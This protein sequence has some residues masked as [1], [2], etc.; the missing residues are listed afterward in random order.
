MNM[1]NITG[2]AKSHPLTTGAVVIGGG[3]TFILLSGWFTG[4][5]DSGGNVTVN[6]AGLSDAEVAASAQLESQRLAAQTQNYSTN[7][8]LKIAE[9]QA[10]LLGKQSELEYLFNIEEL[11]TGKEIAAQT[12]ASQENI[13]ERQIRQQNTLAERNQYDYQTTIR[14]ANDL[15]VLSLQ[16]QERMMGSLLDRIP[17]AQV[18]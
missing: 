18:G 1:S 17:Q 6:Q 13:A 7:A 10:G 11:K 12:I 9:L 5:S 4:G 16:S 15:Q 2:W 8:Q 3:L 14:L